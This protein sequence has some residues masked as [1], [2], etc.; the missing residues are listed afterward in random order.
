[1]EQ[2]GSTPV[3][4]SLVS[5]S[6]VT[7]ATLVY[8]APTPGSGSR[9]LDGRV[10]HEARVLSAFAA[11]EAFA[12]AA[13]R[14]VGETVF[15][16]SRAAMDL[17]GFADARASAYLTPLA[18]AALLAQPVGRVLARLDHPDIAPFVRALG[19]AGQDSPLADALRYAIGA[20]P[21][22]TLRDAMRFAA[23]RDALAREYARGFEVTRELARP[24]LLSALS[25]ADS[26]RGVL[27]QAYLE[28]LSEVPDLD[29][30]ARAGRGEAEDVARMA[31][32]V[33]KAGGVH[34]RRGLEGI[35]NLDG[36]LRADGR[37]APTATE[38]P[39]IAAA[40]LVSLE[41]GPDALNHRLRPATGTGRSR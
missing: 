31:T 13:E 30:A 2:P 23:G 11:G 15:G 25:R 37:L 12:R 4:G 5:R 35:A 22:A 39:V 27:V 32:G 19:L 9:Y 3:P 6:A 40:F 36:L 29:I 1:M 7:A 28:V 41:Y 8:S 10:A 16:A 34:S 14:S 33:L 24:A 21:D 18:R 38:P 26:V 20:G 17:A